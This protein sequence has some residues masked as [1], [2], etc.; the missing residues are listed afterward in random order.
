MNIIADENIYEPI[1]E[2]LK[3]EG[4]S[5]FS[6]RNSELS[7][8]SDDDI[9]QAAVKNNLLIITMDKDFTRT[10]RFPPERCQGIIV[11]QFYRMMVNDATELFKKR[12]KSLNIKRTSNRLVIMTKD[13]IQIR[14]SPKLS[15]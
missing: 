9:Y 1:I 3:S 12:F 8:S 4:H 7:G 15:E 13:E 2:F 14:A 6:V 11:V 5:V 10:L